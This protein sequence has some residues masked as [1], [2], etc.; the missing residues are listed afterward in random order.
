VS[1]IQGWFDSAD[2]RQRRWRLILGKDDSADNKGNSAESGDGASGEEGLSEEDQSLD[3]ALDTVYGD[4]GQGDLSDSA[5]DI[6]R[7]LGDIREYFPAPMVQVMQ[8]DAL[9]RMKL[10]KVLDEPELLAQIEPNVDLV[11]NIL[12]LKKVMPSKTK[13]TAKSVVRQVVEELQKQLRY[14]L[15]QAITGSLHRATRTNRPKFNEIDWRRTIHANLK[16][17]QPELGTVIPEKVIGFG[18]KQNSLRDIIICMD[19]SGSMASSVVYASI[20]AAVLASLKAVTTRLIMFDT[21]VVDVSDQ[22]SDPVELLFG[23]RLG[24]GTNIERAIG[25]CQQQVTRPHD[26]VLILITDLFEGG[27]KD[28]LR[29]RVEALVADGVQVVVLLALNDQ[30]SPR[31]NRQ[32]AQEMVNIGVPSFACTPQLFPDLM[33]AVLDRRDLQQWTATQGIVTAPDN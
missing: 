30:G 22:L 1:E 11:A 9:K 27:D 14:P 33:A 15:E 10:R 31:F 6:A 12:A 29:K 17:Y 3:Q 13:E 2:E 16:H 5:P 32:I 20:Y 23:I 26:T 18:R 19:T 8:Q 21:A 25:Y 7:W 4:S 24:G 28:G